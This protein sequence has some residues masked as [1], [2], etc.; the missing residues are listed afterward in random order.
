M[1]Q[2]IENGTMETVCLYSPRSSGPQFELVGV[3]ALEEERGQTGGR[4]TRN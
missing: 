1:V 2:T 4:E 3:T